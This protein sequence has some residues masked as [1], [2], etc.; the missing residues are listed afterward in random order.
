MTIEQLPPRKVIEA[1]IHE[2]YLAPDQSKSLAAIN[3]AKD[4]MRAHSEGFLAS[5]DPRG[6][7]APEGETATQDSGA[8]TDN[9]LSIQGRL[10]SK[11]A[12]Q[13]PFSRNGDT[14]M[15]MIPVMRVA[16]SDM[17]ALGASSEQIARFLRNTADEVVDK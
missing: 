16:I 14:I 8:T 15:A 5:R 2:G 12:E 3:A 4:A 7:D 1:L 17:R 9:V 13:E 11:A 6:I 10:D